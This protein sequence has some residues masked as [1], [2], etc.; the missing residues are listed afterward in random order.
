MFE[1]IPNTRVISEPYS[2]SFVWNMYLRGNVS[3][4][5]YEHLLKSTF[6]IQCKKENQIQRIVMKQDV[7]ATS[8]LRTLKT[9][10]PEI[11]LVFI[12]RHPLPTLK[13]YSKLW[14]VLPVSGTLAFLA[15][16]NGILWKNYPIPCDDVEWWRRY[17]NVIKE[18][19]TLDQRIA[20]A[21]IFFYSYWCVVDQYI[22]NKKFYEKAILYE[23]LCKNPLE[24][25][26]D[27]FSALNIY[28]DNTSSA[29]R[30]LEKDSQQ[31]F[32]GKRGVYMV[33]DLSTIMDLIDEKFKQHDISMNVAISMEKLRNIIL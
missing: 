17:R 18:G 32:F 33:K 25:I 27:M 16:V 19:R 24:V 8:C 4:V 12:T 31:G 28:I 29:L 1:S 23:D 22:K 20:G 14:T 11:K 9:L 6:Q 30:A 5:E 15:N 3:Y 26:S 10:F 2:F 21:R 13:S 7:S